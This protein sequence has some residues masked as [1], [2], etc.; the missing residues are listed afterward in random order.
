MKQIFE[1]VKMLGDGLVSDFGF[2]NL[3]DFYESMVHTKFLFLTLPTSIITFSVI[4]QWLGL[5]GAVFI[6]FGVMA[7]MELITG[8]WGAKVTGTKLTSR[9]FSRFG[10][11]ILVW[12]SLILVA[13]SF[14]ISY[15]GLEGFQNLLIY[16]LFSWIHGVLVVYITMEYMISILEN[17]GKINGETD[18]KLLT[19]LKKKL[20]QFLGA[21]DNASDPNNFNGTTVKTDLD[22]PVDDLNAQ[23]VVE[24]QE[25][26]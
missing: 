14:K 8:L 5:S 3:R 2:N 13:N 1:Y 21:A 19:F 24:P 26:K 17:M 23:E 25:D 20:D 7:V 4:Q 22:S 16:Q 6:S 15:Q 9:K 12:L 18:N 11:K 10:L